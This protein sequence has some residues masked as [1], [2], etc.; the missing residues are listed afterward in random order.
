MLPALLVA[1]A[2]LGSVEKPPNVLVLLLD[3]IGND[4]VG[5]Y[6]EGDP[7]ERPRT[8]FLDLLAKRSVRFTNAYAYPS[9][10]P[11]R[12]SMLTGRYPFRH[13]IGEK[14]RNRD[15]FALPFEEFTLPEVLDA[16][17]S[18]YE[19]LAIGKWHLGTDGSGG[20]RHPC[21]QGFR[22]FVGT[23]SNVADY[24]S[25]PKVFAERYGN[26]VE[27]TSHA[28]LTIDQ[29]DEALRRIPRLPEPWFVWMAYN[30]AHGPFH[31]PPAHLH[32]RIDPQGAFENYRAM[33]ES[34]DHEIGRLV[35]GLR[36]I[37]PR[38]VLIVAG[39]NGTPGPVSFVSPSKGSLYEGG[40]NV[41]LMISGPVVPRPNAGAV[42]DALVLLQDVFATVLDVASVDSTG[43]FPDGYALD[44]VSLLPVLRDPST[45]VRDHAVAERFS[46]NGFGP[47]QT[48]RWMIR[49][50]RYKL[51]VNEF[52][53][54][55]DP[56]VQLFDLLLAPTGE[57]GEDLCPCPG[58]LDPEGRAAWT[59]LRAKLLEIRGY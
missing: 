39:D 30:A 5:A 38:T 4:M 37:L 53:A 42:S 41:P 8:P 20:G 31:E 27:T 54:P 55:N 26:L 18:G 51:L 12:A 34:L 45:R 46:R 43:V 52:P 17:R 3:D 50:E 19:H 58:N 40:V 9:C 2:L 24:E 33:V 11:T 1:C 57:D 22:R 48:H 35:R 14:I 47:Y 56:T 13:G 28:Y 44:S 6:G 32:D 49:N 10:S 23:T 36:N 25:W 59:E 15:G 16:A 7:V 29:T 21:L